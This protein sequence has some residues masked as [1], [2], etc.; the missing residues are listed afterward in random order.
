MSKE[1]SSPPYLLNLIVNIS[2][3]DQIAV[4]KGLIMAE[5]GIE[6]ERRFKLLQHPSDITDTSLLMSQW[7]LPNTGSWSARCRITTSAQDGMRSTYDQT[8]KRDTTELRTEI[9]QEEFC[10]IKSRCYP[11][12]IQKRRY[13][14]QGSD[15][16]WELDEF[17]NLA[18]HGMTI[19]EIELPSFNTPFEQPDWLGSEITGVRWFSNASLSRFLNAPQDHD[20]VI[21]LVMS[22][23]GRK[24]EDFT[25]AS[26]L[27]KILDLPEI[28]NNF[29]TSRELLAQL[30]AQQDGYGIITS[31][32][33]SWLASAKD[34]T[35]L[36]LVL[37]SAFIQRKYNKKK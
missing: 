29:S 1:G 25:F 22:F 36:D 34:I 28:D 8:M 13:H 32:E 37:A 21:T 10:T 11:V 14:Y 15:Y 19:A 2:T 27:K 7:Y 16:L 24:R 4:M 6:I 17:R 18:I 20:D 5:R 30:I 12:G 35:L 31:V 23:F 26:S 3:L 33:V 9:T